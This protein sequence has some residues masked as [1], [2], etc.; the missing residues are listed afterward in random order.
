[1]IDLINLTDADTDTLNNLTHI[2]IH[3][4]EKAFRRIAK[5]IDTG[6]LTRSTL[7]NIFMPLSMHII[8][9]NSK[10]SE[11]ILRDVA[12]EVIASISRQLPWK[13]Y[14]SLIISLFRGLKSAKGKSAK[15][16]YLKAVCTVLDNFHFEIHDDSQE[17]NANNQ[18]KKVVAGNSSAIATLPLETHAIPKVK[19]DWLVKQSGGRIGYAL[20]TKLIPQIMDYLTEKDKYGERVRG[21][22][23]LVLIKVLRVLPNP[24]LQTDLPRVLLS[25]CQLLQD[26]NQRA[27][28]ATRKVV[29]EVAISLGSPYLA[30]LIRELRHALSK[31]YQIHVLSYTLQ[32]ILRGM[33]P[34]LQIGD[35]DDCITDIM[36][37]IMEDL[38][39]QVSQQ[40]EKDS[41]YKSTMREAKDCKSWNSL[42]LLCRYAT[43]ETAIMPIIDPLIE[44]LGDAESKK[45][46]NKVA[47]AL[48]RVANGVSFHNDINL[49]NAMSFLFHLL[50]QYLE[51]LERKG[52][53][54]T[55]QTN[56]GDSTIIDGD[57]SQT[58]V[59]G[60]LGVVVHKNVL[61]KKQMTKQDRSSTFLIPEQP[62][63]T[64]SGRYI[65][66]KQSGMSIKVNS[67]IIVDFCLRLLH[68][69]VKRGIIQ[70]TNSSHCSLLDPFV[71][72]ITRCANSKQDLIIVRALKCINTILTWPLSSLDEY[73]PEVVTKVM[74]ILHKSGSTGSDLV[75]S[76]FKIITNILRQR[77]K[78]VLQDDHFHA[79]LQLV[80]SDISDSSR[81][82]ASFSLFK[83]ILSRKFI[84]EKLY[85]LVQQISVL[86]L[87]D[88]RDHIRNTCSSIF[89]QV[90]S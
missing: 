39:G 2:Q 44:V 74:H 32:E 55:D 13:W 89:V 43:F 29:V 90:C 33:S 26:R 53:T 50:I 37:I 6:N 38:F 73:L 48:D 1:M 64:V 25:I 69:L 20:R 59:E 61:K 79:L 14:L 27:R 68:L 81:Q 56:E 66:S 36:E 41:G 28:D 12:V 4:R 65:K 62:K 18:E 83:S 3:R 51:M 60:K 80:A 86:M 10:E 24:I 21:P 58:N 82:V 49:E 42:E 70:Q 71:P 11:H 85:D 15:R 77:N 19:N 30:L 35:L 40:K 45:K 67:Y 54:S 84:S 76:C 78:I 57:E 22:V 88:A 46:V 72:L 63:M 23:A 16:V 5:K 75:Q 9:E 8:T 52:T 7:C 47:K 17:D 31:G 34:R 87:E